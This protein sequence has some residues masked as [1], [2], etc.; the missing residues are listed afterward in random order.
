SALVIKLRASRE[1]P[2]AGSDFG[3]SADVENVS[4]K[5]IY[6]KPQAF[7]MTAPPELDSDGPKDW[8]AWLPGPHVGGKEKAASDEKTASPAKGGNPADSDD[9][10]AVFKKVVVVAPHSKMSA[11]WSGNLQTGS[12][13]A[14]WNSLCYIIGEDCATLI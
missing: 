11:F 8:F 2:S 6:L 12:Q 4:D 9:V 3:I 7:T 14:G 10:P 1:Q 13:K 5:P